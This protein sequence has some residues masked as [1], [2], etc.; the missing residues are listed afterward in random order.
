MSGPFSKQ[1]IPGQ[2]IVPVTL[3]D[4]PLPDGPA[5][6]LWVGTAGNANITT[7]AGNERDDVPLQAGLFPQG[8]THVRP[9]ASV[10]AAS[11]IWAIY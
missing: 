9:G 10:T 11:N 6:A 5:R 2:D 3:S 1:I 8:V 4:D 7:L